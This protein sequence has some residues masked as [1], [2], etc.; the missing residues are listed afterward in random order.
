M[1]DL[2]NQ[3]TPSEDI[4][5]LCIYNIH[6]C[7]RVFTRREFFI[8]MVSSVSESGDVEDA[9]PIKIGG[10]ALVAEAAIFIWYAARDSRIYMYT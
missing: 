1:V 3:R 7:Y 2:G 6:T 5:A 9:V 8:Y 10:E 4:K